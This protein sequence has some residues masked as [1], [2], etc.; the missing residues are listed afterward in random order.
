MARDPK[1][2]PVTPRS[3]AQ[4]SRPTVVPREEERR[5]D[6]RREDDRYRGDTIRAFGR[7]GAAGEMTLAGPAD[8]VRWGPIVAGLVTGVSLFLLL[9]LLALGLGLAA[10]EAGADAAA[11][12]A[13]LIGGIVAAIIGLA[14]FFVGGYV[15]GRG[16]A[17]VGRAAGAF[18][19]FLVWGLGLVLILWLGVAGLGTLFGA[20][21]DIFAALPAAGVQP[22]AVDPG[23][24]EIDPAAAGDAVRDSA[25]ISFFALGLP[26][27]AAAIGGAVGVRTPEDVTR[28]RA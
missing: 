3:D 25:F 5:H 19:G 10:A 24:V 13:G 6:E 21:G 23:A 18:N 28:A 16:S 15:A 2:D 22:G 20:A 4:T 17:V 9:S 14:A 11:D 7:T 1:R 26:A 12:D 8:Q 27:L